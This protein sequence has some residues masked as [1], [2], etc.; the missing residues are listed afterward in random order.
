MFAMVVGGAFYGYIIGTVTSIVADMD[1][2]ARAYANRMDLVQS[3]LD[4][5]GDIPKSLRRRVRKSYQMVLAHQSAL[6]DSAILA[7]LSPELRADMAFFIIHE[8]VRANPMFFGIANG[9]LANLVM[10]LQHNSTFANE[11][12]VKIGNPGVAMY[13]LV[14]GTARYDKGSIWRPIGVQIEGEK[15]HKLKEGESFGEEIIFGLE[16]TYT[17]TIVAITNCQ[18]HSISEDG[19]KDTYKN[20]P[21][22]HDHMHQNF[23]QVRSRPPP[24][25]DFSLSESIRECSAPLW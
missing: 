4:C 23:I 18:F 25:K 13:S 20:L 9:A 24:S 15:F 12:I 6:D 22:V 8:H 21:Q 14:E 7:E 1:L 16:E 11:Y 10:V 19:F 5:H 17:Y 3:W 2:N